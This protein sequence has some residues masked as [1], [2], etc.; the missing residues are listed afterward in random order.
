MANGEYTGEGGAMETF[1][2]LFTAEK[3]KRFDATINDV[4][5]KMGKIPSERR[6]RVTGDFN[7]RVSPELRKA[8][9]DWDRV[10]NRKLVNPFNKLFSKQK[11]RDTQDFF[12]KLKLTT[13]KA[14]DNYQRELDAIQGKSPDDKDSEMFKVDTSI[15]D[16]IEE[17]SQANN[18]LKQLTEERDKIIA[19]GK[20]LDLL[21][22][23]K[24]IQKQVNKTAQELSKVNDQLNRN[25][26]I[27]DPRAKANIGD[28]MKRAL[29]EHDDAS[30][31]AVAIFNRTG[32]KTEYNQLKKLLLDRGKQYETQLNE[33]AEKMQEADIK[34]S[35]LEDVYN[36]AQE[37]M[38]LEPSEDNRNMLA[39]A[40]ADLNIQKEKVRELM[41]QKDITMEFIKLNKLEQHQNKMNYRN[42]AKN[43]IT[44]ETKAFPTVELPQKFQAQL[45][46]SLKADDEVSNRV[47]KYTPDYYVKDLEGRR[48]TLMAR[49]SN[50]RQKQRDVGKND[51][52]KEDNK[53]KLE[54][55]NNQIKQQ[56]KLVKGVE[57]EVIK[58]NGIYEKLEQQVT[59][60][61]SKMQQLYDDTKGNP[62][63]NE[64]EAEPLQGM[65]K[66]ADKLNSKWGNFLKSF[67]Q[68]TFL[69]KIGHKVMWN[70]YTQ[71]ATFINPLNVF[72]RAWNDWINRWDNLPIKNTFEVIAYNLVNVLEPVLKQFATLL[73]KLA[74]VANVFT[75]KWFNID[76]FDK[77]AWYTEK[78][79]KNASALTASFDELHAL[80][81]NPNENNTGFDTGIWEEDKLL[82]EKWKKNLEEFADWAKPFMDG[83]GKV[84]GWAL[85]HPI[86]AALAALGL[87]LF[88][89]MILK[90]I[91]KLIGTGL[92]KLFFGGAAKEGAKAGGSFLGN[93]FGKTL[94]TGMKGKAVTVGKL[95]G[96]IALVAGGTAVAI[97]N[98][99]SAGKNWQ[100]LT[101]QQKA[102]KVGFVGL[103]SAAAGFGAIMLGASGLVGCAVAGAVAL[104]AFCVGM[105]QTQ[106]GIESLKKEQEKL[107]DVQNRLAES[108]EK[109]EKSNNDLNEAWQNLKEVEKETGENGERLWKMVKNGTIQV[110]DLTANQYKAYKVYDEVNKKIQ[111]NTKVVKENN[112]LIRE[113]AKQTAS[114]IYAE[115]KKN[116]DSYDKLAEHINTCWE[117]GTMTTEQAKDEISRI[118]A[119]MSES[120]RQELLEKLR[121]ALQEGLDYEK[122]QSGWN[123]FGR[124]WEEF[125]TNAVGVH[126][127][128]IADMQATEQDLLETTDK[129]REAQENLKKAQEELT[130]AE[131]IAGMTAEEL[132]AKIDS[133]EISVNN[134][135]E[136]QRRLY[137]ADLK[138]QDGSTLVNQALSNNEKKLV[139]LAKQSYKTSGDW[140]TF[141]DKLKKAND[142]GQISTAT[143][144]REIGIAMGEA[145]ADTEQFMRAYTRGLGIMT[146]D[147][148]KA[149]HE[150]KGFFSS[151]LDSA[152]NTWQKICNWFGGKGWNTNAQVQIDTVLNDSSLSEDE[153]RKRLGQ[154]GVNGFDV[155]TN[156]VPNDQL[157]M[158]HQGEAIIPK[159]YNK[160]YRPEAQSSSAMLET[161][162]A[163]RQEMAM[164]RAKVEQG[165]PVKGE[166]RQRGSDLVAVVERGKNKNGN[167]P[168]NNPAYAR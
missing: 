56:E 100:D 43:R 29:A 10:M 157:A 70:I 48:D 95:L 94:Y 64:L 164:L 92:K 14:M 124:W 108:N 39:Q 20:Q 4:Q 86:Q 58:L 111:E 23:E 76:L 87:R 71:I 79:K 77:G 27:K 90:G 98:A 117:N 7:N 33:I 45:R 85:E 151:L 46:K 82:G 125:W 34:Q 2:V 24:E 40:E 17:L 1:G 3:G 26:S 73:V 166:F 102:V 61:T 120:A 66:E 22:D 25:I 50:L 83:L 30:K 65:N 35:D 134:L 145:D 59:S 42:R 123:K 127:A 146:N 168:L 11:L 147:V 18:R 110:K 132:K 133:G 112:E 47:G 148:E 15:S 153:K 6:L 167:Q 49:Q 13:I 161:M 165:I 91:G 99:A 32:D 152:S 139:G 154:L 60:I 130:Q 156:Y 163:M 81:E 142:E 63:Q 109:L 74:S 143:M 105:S 97:S 93:L 31:K 41:K 36:K 121:P 159:K 38:K 89:P 19:E 103:G 72:K 138:V 131:Q 162:N 12:S 78:M 53:T 55:V 155:G 129:L 149:C 37:S 113:E 52:A 8:F 21:P 69:G 44:A 51:K 116:S 96:G 16:K 107:E 106:N 114:T 122:Y 84:L 136:A 137:D 54:N 128:S 126:D 62:L 9:K 115:T 119:D 5:K 135:T 80:N 67:K 68:L 118:M 141:I 144:A 150:Q 160:P 104:T 140:K 75:K 158:V 88:G 57:N 28:A 101:K